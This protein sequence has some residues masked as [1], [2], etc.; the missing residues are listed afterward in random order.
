MFQEH[1]VKYSKR[2]EAA[3]G[4]SLEGLS[5]PC[6]MCLHG[7]C[8][9]PILSIYSKVRTDLDPLAAVLMFSPQ[10]ENYAFSYSLFGTSSQLLRQQLRILIVLWF[11]VADFAALTVLG[12]LFGWF[13]GF[14]PNAFSGHYCSVNHSFYSLAGY[15]L[16]LGGRV[17]PFSS[18][19]SSR[20]TR[21]P[22]TWLETEQC[23]QTEFDLCF[24]PSHRI[25]Q[26]GQPSLVSSSGLNWYS[27][28]NA[29]AIFSHSALWTWNFYVL[30]LYD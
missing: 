27:E 10:Q 8:I 28:E 4:R 5:W 12:G 21:A 9:L 19:L 15:L 14:S 29:N 3:E 18:N 1:R 22:L 20:V 23:F 7:G 26:H 25:S 6:C 24:F 13:G 2:G 16:M 30:V 11:L 17:S